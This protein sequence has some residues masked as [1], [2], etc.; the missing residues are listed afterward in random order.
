MR[1]NRIKIWTVLAFFLAL[2]ASVCPVAMRIAG[3]REAARQAAALEEKVD[4]LGTEDREMQRNLAKWYNLQLQQGATDHQ[5]AYGNILNF[6]DGA[7]GLLEVP[8]LKLK[9]VIRHGAE[10]AVGHDP[11]TSFPIG[12]RGNHTVLTL[13]EDYPW[14]AG[15]AVYIVCLGE[16]LS[17]R[18]EGVQVMPA[19]WPADRPTDGGQ[20]L[21][22]L[23]CN[24]G[25]TRTIIRCVRS[26]DLTVRQTA[27]PPLPALWMAVSVPAM[28]VL[29]ALILSVRGEQRA[30]NCGN[31]RK[32]RRKTKLF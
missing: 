24:Q 32:N 8:E 17:Y 4:A 15:M 14:A 3:E 20:D 10:G 12:G 11:A 9:L 27:L 1:R 13:T 7:M 2:A 25:K 29:P 16:R 23:I 22:T 28:A 6:G 19:H 21:L 18:V 30:G 5:E 26:Q 31:R